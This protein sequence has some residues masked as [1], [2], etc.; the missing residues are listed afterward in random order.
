MKKQI[1]NN[2]R[3][4]VVMCEPKKIAKVTTINANAFD[5]AEKIKEKLKNEI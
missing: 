3:I 5:L 2:E 1:E 4:T